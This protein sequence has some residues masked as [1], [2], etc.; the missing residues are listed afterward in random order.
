MR[1]YF[2]IT[3][4]VFCFTS[5]RKHELPVQEPFF[6]IDSINRSY[7]LGIAN[8]HAGYNP[9][10]PVSFLFKYDNQNNFKVRVGGF[11][12][13]HYSTGTV[14][15]F[16]TEI[17]DTVI[18][19]NNTVEL[20][21]K[22]SVSG[23]SVAANRR[24]YTLANNKIQMKVAYAT[25]SP[26]QNDTTLYYYHSNKTIDKLVEK[27]Y[28]YFIIK[29]FAFNNSGNLDYVSGKT[30]SSWDNTLVSSTEEMFGNYD[31]S[32]NPLIRFGIWDETYYRSLTVNNFRSY[33]YEK[34][35]EVTNTVLET[36]NIRF[37]LQYNNQGV[38]D[39]SK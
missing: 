26:Q 19:S 28:G 11:I 39:F 32:I 18:Y 38:V 10:A 13:D 25:T 12:I 8:I 20:I 2:F 37:N 9:W 34:K 15:D 3:V 16:I 22:S 23:L 1:I 14:T 6:K 29:T 5:C 33:S 30:Y 21:T 7:L 36:R 4:V 27:H 35:D 17:Y 24:V 31:S